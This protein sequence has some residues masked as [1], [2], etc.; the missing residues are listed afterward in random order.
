MSNAYQ[1]PQ[2]GASP[3]PPQPPAT[4]GTDV[5]LRNA[6]GSISIT[7]PTVCASINPE[8]VQPVTY[9]TIPAGSLLNGQPL[10]V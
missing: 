3:Y 2:T 8:A 1:Q 6:N 5:A 9:V 7:S 4:Q 10:T